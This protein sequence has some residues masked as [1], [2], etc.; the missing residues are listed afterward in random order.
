M[1]RIVSISLYLCMGLGLIPD[2]ASANPWQDL[3]QSDLAFIHQQLESNHPGSVDPQNQAFGNWLIGGLATANADISNV[4]TLED[5]FLVLRGYVAGFRDPHV[6]V[7]F[8]GAEPDLKWPGFVVVGREGKVI[9]GTNT[10]PDGPPVGAQLLSCDGIAVNN[11]LADRVF[12]FRSSPNVSASFDRSVRYLFFSAENNLVQGTLRSCEFQ[13]GDRTITQQLNWQSVIPEAREL[14]ARTDG[15]VAAKASLKKY[16]GDVYWLRVPSFS[17]D[18]SN[19]KSLE[20]LFRLVNR[21]QADI[22]NSQAL[23]IDVRGNGGGSSTFGEIL[24]YLLF[25]RE[26]LRRH[27]DQG[28]PTINIDWRASSDNLAYAKTWL[29]PNSPRHLP[30]E[31]WTRRIIDGMQAA[32]QAGN[33]YFRESVPAQTFDEDPSTLPYWAVP[34][35]ASKSNLPSFIPPIPLRSKIFVLMDGACVSACLDFIDYLKHFE[36]I[37]YLGLPTD[38]DTQYLDT[39]TVELPSQLGSLTFPMKVYR[40]R[41]RTPGQSYAPDIAYAGIDRS[42]NTLRQWALSVVRSRLPGHS[43]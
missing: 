17:S 14:F 15:D 18:P 23:V 24:V 19:R 8:T 27:S 35:D 5:Y 30:A 39:R 37:T 1:R 16:D 11:L 21:N 3:A 36:G 13:V 43:Q 29:D 28:D 38:A 32:Y 42:E 10:L 2:V 41:L 4:K 20:N 31:D 34:S 26:T 7:G 9:V 6:Y 22:A 12:R 25:D 33:P 40:N